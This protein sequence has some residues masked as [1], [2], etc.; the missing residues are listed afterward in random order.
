MGHGFPRFPTL[1]RTWL[2][3][4]AACRSSPGSFRTQRAHSAPSRGTLSLSL[5]LAPSLSRTTA[6]ARSSRAKFARWQRGP[7]RRSGGTC[8]EARRR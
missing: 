6:S 8:P 3:A 7:S 5:S 2:T 4:R 1:D